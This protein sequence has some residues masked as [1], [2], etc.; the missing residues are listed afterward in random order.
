MTI[1]RLSY[2]S[3]LSL[4]LLIGA[5]ALGNR[6]TVPLFFGAD[7]LFGS[8]A[9]M[10]VI[11][12]Y[13]AG[14][15]A[16]SALLV[17][18]PTYF[19]WG[20]AYALIVFVTES[21][22][23]GI[24]AYRWSRANLLLLDG[25]F[26]S[27]IGVPLCLWLYT[28]VLGIDATGTTLVIL[29]Q[30]VNGLFNTLI[31]VLA[32]TH[33]PLNRWLQ[34][35]DERFRV[36]IADTLFTMMVSFLMVPSLLLTL[37]ASRHE[38]TTM[39]REV[40]ALLY[41][42]T[43]HVVTQIGLWQGEHLRRLKSLATIAARPNQPV[44]GMTLSMRNILEHSPGFLRLGVVT[45]D[46]SL[47]A[48]VN[49]Q[50]AALDDSAPTRVSEV[51]EQQR[52]VI[53]DLYATTTAPGSPFITISQ[54]IMQEGRLIGIAQGLLDP[55]F[56]DRLLGTRAET[57]LVHVTL[58]DRTGKV[59]G[60]SRPDLSTLQPFDP[61]AGS[62]LS[63]L[64]SGR[65]HR[66]PANQQAT[67][68]R[69][70]ESDQVLESPIPGEGGWRVVAE[71]SLEPY[72]TRLYQFYIRN[73]SLVLGLSVLAMF[74]SALISRWLTRPLLEL[75]AITRYLPQRLQVTEP[76]AWPTSRMAEIDALTTDIQW[77]TGELRDQFDEIERDARQ[78]QALLSSAIEATGAPILITDAA[79]RIV[80]ANPPFY[81]EYGYTPDEILGRRSSG[82]P[83]RIETELIL[84]PLRDPQGNVTHYVGIHRN[85]R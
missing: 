66:F 9:T 31:A 71:V 41:R 27:L 16:L 46:G 82:L 54:P 3:V 6:F 12:F 26:W 77:M 67:L 57:R 75:T 17:S 19:L 10:L 29:K 85:I 34:G 48:A 68:N 35:S 42:E 20:H 36:P 37:V 30:V 72:R 38:L 65:Y 80:Y 22:V 84:S 81:Q 74:L 59:I 39:N 55:S 60:T 11:R 28:P 18:L 4:A 15:G 25:L 2:R 1:Q 50:G 70:R 44:D 5:G 49:R 52:L 23:V 64:S 56:A 47:V 13:G 79:K 73:L 69:W 7:L 76:I 14:W 43:E 40:E 51:R 33:L 83:G 21:V 62:E 61:T 45:P 24:L 63:W 58:L 78:Q 53:S 8:I 32:I